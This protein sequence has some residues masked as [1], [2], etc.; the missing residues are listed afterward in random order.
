MSWEPLTPP[1]LDAWEASLRACVGIRWRH[2]GRLGMGYGHQSGL[3]CVGL[4]LRA[5]QDIGRQVPD[6][7]LYGRDPDGTLESQL[8]ARLGAPSPLRPASV[9]MLRLPREPSHVGYVARNGNLIHCY[10]ST[11][12][13]EHPLD[14]GWRR[15]IVRSWSV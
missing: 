6:V 14:D 4:L 13:T 10:Y 5:A 8:T 12:V 3:D 1:E 11:G 7:P 9:V 2:R 15:R